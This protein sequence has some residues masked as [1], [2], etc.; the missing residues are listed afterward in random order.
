M[1]ALVGACGD[2]PEPRPV[3][4]PQAATFL[5]ALEVLTP[6]QQSAALVARYKKTAETLCISGP[7][8]KLW[9]LFFTEHGGN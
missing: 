7:G 8:V 9:P 2:E 5:L 1:S 4:P 3:A 6:A